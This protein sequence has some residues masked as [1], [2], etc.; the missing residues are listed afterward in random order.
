LFTDKTN[1]IVINYVYSDMVS[2]FVVQIAV[3]LLERPSLVATNFAQPLV[4]VLLSISITTC[5]VQCMFCEVRNSNLRKAPAQLVQGPRV[6]TVVVQCPKV[7]RVLL[8][9]RIQQP[10]LQLPDVA[11]AFN[12]ARIT[13][14]SQCYRYALRSHR[15]TCSHSVLFYTGLL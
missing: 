8:T 13:S 1:Q 11:A 7:Q 6:Q 14:A 15:I 5:R 12:R 2:V 4:T 3:A 10:R 9:R